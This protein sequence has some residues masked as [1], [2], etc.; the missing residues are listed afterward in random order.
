MVNFQPSVSETTAGWSKLP[1]LFLI[2]FLLTCQ[3]AAGQNGKGDELSEKE[4]YK[5]NELF[6]QAEKEK[7][8]GNM[9][10]ALNL[11]DKLY[12]MAPT[13]ATVAY[14]MAR[15]YT[16]EGKQDEAV[17][18]A[19]RAVEL[20]PENKWFL[21]LLGSV[22][23]NFQMDNKEIEVFEKL[24]ELDST[25]P[26]Y[27]YELAMAYYGNDQPEKAI[28]ELNS[29][30]NLVGINEEISTQ[31]KQLYL[32]Q[33][34]L[35]GAV[36]E[37]Q[38]LIDAYPKNVEYR[39]TLAQMYLVNGHEDK[40]LQV[41]ED[42][43]KIAPEDPRPHLD[44]AKLY[45]KRGEYAK[46]LHHLEI[47]MYSPDL[48]IDQKVP[49]LLSLFEASSADSLLQQSAYKMLDSVISQNPKDPKAYAIYG[50]FLSRDGR[51]KEALESYLKATHLEG[52]NRFQIWEQILLIEIQAQMYDSLLVHGPEALEMFPNQPLP[53]F[54]TGV[55]HNV[56][57]E[58]NQA[59]GYLEDGLVY[60]FGNPRLKEQFYSQ[61]AE[62]YHMLGEGKSSNEYFD[63]AL[64]LNN[65]NP[66]VLNNYAYYLSERGENLDKALEM[67]EKSNNLA[68]GNPTFIDTWAWVLYK[69]GEYE[70][71]LDK[72]E[73]LI[74][75]GGA[76][77]GEV[78]EHYGDI[79]YK[80]GRVD[81]AVA[82]WRLAKSLGNASEKIDEKINSRK[83]VN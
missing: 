80:N 82:Q 60:V 43:M 54:F 9:D 21:L 71:A 17:S 12:K 72:M 74:Q 39:G 77:T 83:L 2:L 70:A 65:Q 26:D 78:V 69:R 81:D 53:Y 45:R 67:T 68:P 49:V 15:I 48:D 66:T 46:S 44:L 19:E 25:N 27:R 28:A 62:A 29:L 22:Y 30:E 16:A 33:G 31:K 61:L 50:D 47:A 64:A 55:A 24:V 8:L 40:A 41:Y 76:E 57:G 79:L 52:G 58:Y 34:N 73:K 75:L 10:E 42:L 38:A 6:F 1:G 20:E 4:R 37:V 51:N 36:K 56:K 32:D 35:E 7:N 18:Y 5:F 59:I 3:L 14:E 63:K 11:Y 13:N 23:R